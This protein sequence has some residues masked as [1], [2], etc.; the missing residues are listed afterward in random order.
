MHALYRWEIYIA[1]GL[2]LFVDNFIFWTKGPASEYV[3]D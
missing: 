2:K 1:R 3:G